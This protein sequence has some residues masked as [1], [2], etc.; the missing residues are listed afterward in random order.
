MGESKNICFFNTT[1]FWGGGEKWHFEAAENMSKTENSTFF[2]CDEKGE[3]AKKLKGLD[4]ILHNVTASNL[5]FLNPSKINKLIQF[6]RS[7][8]I[9]TVIFNNPKDLKLGGRAAKKA[10]VK[11]I[12]YRRGIA[13]EV[14]KSRLNAHLFGAVVTHFIFNSNATK[15]LLEKNYKHI[16][17]TKKTAIIY[18][19]I[20]FPREKE[21][22]KAIRNGQ[23][24]IIGNAGRLVAQK[25]QHFLLDI[26]E[27]LNEKELDFKIQIAGDGP[28]YDD[29]KKA[30]SD[31]NLVDKIELFGFVEDMSSFMDGV[32]IF[33][34]T[35]VWE[36]FGFVLAEAMVAKKPVLAFDMSS[37]PELVKD[38]ENGYLIPPKN[39]E[40]FAGRIEELINNK[41]LR[42]KLGD[43]AY[44]F[45]KANFETEKQIQ[46]LLDFIT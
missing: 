12:V 34:S 38:G 25:A 42:D 26:A 23:Q 11:N 24:I 14:K 31:R 21:K 43:E 33:V 19:A 7:N 18:N 37:N 32:D 10:G 30:I 4:I 44:S 35:A 1:S 41:T 22:Q 8:S 46:K 17:P 2:V 15:E 20:E 29:L 45:A 39:V 36:G 5:S 3:L 9:D 13:V 6:Y 40:V 16:V 27:K 28:L